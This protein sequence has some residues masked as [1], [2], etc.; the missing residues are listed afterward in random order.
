MS[1]I[2]RAIDENIIK[3][4]CFTIIIQPI[5]DAIIG[6]SINVYLINELTSLFRMIILVFYI[7]YFITIYKKV[8]LIKRKYLY[9]LLLYCCI[10]ILFNNLMFSAIKHLLRNFYFLIMFIIFLAICEEKKEKIPS[11]YLIIS[12]FIYSS[13][14]FFAYITNTAFS[15]YLDIKVGNSGYF[16]AANDVGTVLSIIFPLLPMYVY[17]NLNYKNIVIFII[18]ITAILILGTKTP[19][20]AMIVTFFMY[21]LSKLSKV[22]IKLKNI[23]K[24]I[25]LFFIIII[26][27]LKII[28][29]TPL[30]EN[31]MIH[32]QFLKVNNVA[33]LVTDYRMFDHFFLGSRLSFLNN[34]TKIYLDSNLSEKLLGVSI[35]D[36][37][38][39]SEMDLH[40]LFH[41][42]GVIGFTIYSY[43]LISLLFNKNNQFNK[44]YIIPSILAI[45]ISIIVGHGLT[46]PSAGTFIA[47]IFT[48]LINFKTHK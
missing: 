26:L 45:A 37:P 17:K 32:A 14:I 15:S 43:V 13:I 11:K 27:G 2:N 31:T 8:D 46:S 10:Y 9:V 39:K 5:I 42:F 22:N 44:K 12:I 23:W 16:Y 29:T 4:M 36:M 34:N 33:A 30:Y 21:I 38:K 7:Y 35:N 20:I 18:I 47:V 28:R 24:L 25:L 40:D 41:N 6:Y 3:I 48:N 19:F 1:K